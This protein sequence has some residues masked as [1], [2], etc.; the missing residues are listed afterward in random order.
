MKHYGDFYIDGEWVRPQ[1]PRPFELIDPAT[2]KAFASVSLGGIE[3]VNRAV[4]AARKALPSFRATSKAYRVELLE[5]IIESFRAREDEIMSAISM[6]MGA[7]LSLKAQTSASIDSLQQTL[8]VLKAYAFET[9]LGNDIVRRE[10]IGVCGLINA[11]NW[12][13]QTLCVKWSSALAAGCTV[14]IK[15][16][17]YTSLSAILFAQA[18]HAA[19]LPAGVFNL[20]LGDG[21]TVGHA[22]SAHADVDLVS[23]TGSTRAGILVAEAAAPSV[24]RVAQELGGK[25]AHIVM[26][27]A[28]LQAAASWNVQRAFLNTGQSCHSPTR[29]LVHESQL[30]QFLALM[31]QEADKTRIGDPR[32]P[33]V[34]MGPVVNKAQFE[35]IQ[36]YIQIGMDE[37]ARLVCG[38]LGRPDGM[39][40]GYFVK[41]TIFADVASSMTIAREEIFGPVLAVMS[42][43]NEDE[44]IAIANDT[45][46]GLGAYIFGADPRKALAMGRQLQAG[47]VFYNGAPA[48]LTAPSGGYKKSGNGREM[49]VYGLEEYL[50]VKALLGFDE[51]QGELAGA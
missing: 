10:A 45:P 2:E 30:E 33:A 41:P 17:E 27:D 22:I 47:R 3:D 8:E 13:V 12:P 5:R 39:D 1:N 34:T 38:G 26:R 32:N 14:V 23:F 42:Y 36:R 43:A 35:R 31:R 19:G 16:S 4:A 29:T 50:E 20:V 9:L 15:P 49:G 51:A 44:A 7:P 40:R 46:Y 48:N 24:K 28:D 6:E 21:P 11:W 18:V 25:S 37:G